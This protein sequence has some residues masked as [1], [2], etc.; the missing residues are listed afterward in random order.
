MARLRGRPRQQ[1]NPAAKTQKPRRSE[2][3]LSPSQAANSQKH[4]RLEGQRS[5]GLQAIIMVVWLAKVNPPRGSPRHQRE[6]HP[7]LSSFISSVAFISDVAVTSPCSSLHLQ[8]PN[9]PVSTSFVGGRHRWYRYSPYHSATNLIITI[10]VIIASSAL[11]VL[12]KLC[13]RHLYLVSD[14]LS[15]NIHSCAFMER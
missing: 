5:D 12:Y 1:L 11:V 3:K 15:L 7:S 14:R 4:R 2:V 10:V 13:T 6:N 9:L 8:L